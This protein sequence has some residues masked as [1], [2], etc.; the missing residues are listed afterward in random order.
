MK[1]Y[2]LVSRMS[3]NQKY[4]F[5]NL[6]MKLALRSGNV[7]EIGACIYYSVIWGGK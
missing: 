1:L 2:E 3:T 6:I 5:A 4:E 7:N